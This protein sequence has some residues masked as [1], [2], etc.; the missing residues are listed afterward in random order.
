MTRILI[1]GMSG[2]GK[3]TLL[4]ELARRGHA[5]VDTDEDGWTEE[6]TGLWDEHRID[7]LLAAH[8]DIIVSGTVENQGS[9]YDCFDEVILLSAPLD[10]LL[11]RVRTRTA[12]PYG[13][14]AV[15]QDEIRRY[16]VE[17]EPLLRAG[18]TAEFDGTEPVAALADAVEHLSDAE[19]DH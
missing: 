1:T 15:Q 19:R 4:A 17:V 9:F 5:T 8:E 12:N 13:R 16:V 10:V 2:A 18:A 3:S 6:A 11:E 14:T 7:V